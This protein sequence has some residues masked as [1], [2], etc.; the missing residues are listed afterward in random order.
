MKKILV[1]TLLISFSTQL[2]AWWDPGHLVVA[3]IA[4]MQLDDTAKKEVNRLTKIAQRDY[5]YTNHFITL[6]A[7][8]DDLKAEGVRSF[9]TWHYTNIP[10]NPDR[11]ALP[12]HQEVDVI[13][14]INQM[15]Q[16]LRTEKS[17]DIDKAR[18]LGFLVHFVGDIHQPL[19][20]T[21]HFSDE[22]PSGDAGGNEFNLQ[23][24]YRNL[25]SMWDDGCGFL[26]HMNDISPY[27]KPKE[28]LKDEGINR[29]Q[30]LAKQ[31]LSDFDQDISVCLDETDPDFWALESHKLAVKYGYKGK[32]GVD[33][34]GRNQYIKP[35]NTP[36]DLYIENGK[37]IVQQQ[38]VVAGLR[39][40]KMLN[41]I[42][43]ETG[44]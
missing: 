18:H 23:G 44:K 13:W 9:D 35:G 8:P 2:K 30:E 39:L 36:S 7:W 12:D 16:V 22:N 11:V 6:G 37:K 28:A 26:S 42:Y 40:G 20:C 31:L 43:G 33:D 3:M 19:H 27:G 29:Y 41:D 1:L 4:Y 15:N 21:S 38:L 17:R 10:Y 32:M 34:R 25:H 24:K 14:A 5:P